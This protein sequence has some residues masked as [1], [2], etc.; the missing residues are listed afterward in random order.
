MVLCLISFG[1]DA[2][3]LGVFAGASN[4]ASVIRQSPLAVVKQCGVADDIAKG[5]QHVML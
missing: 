3:A 4:R 1:V 5:I 2:P